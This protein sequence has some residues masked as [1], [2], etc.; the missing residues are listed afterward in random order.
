MNL[1]GWSIIRTKDLTVYKA[2]HVKVMKLIKCS[3]WFSGWSDLD[4]IWRYIFDDVN[5]GGI[6][7][8]RED[9]AKVRGTDE[10]GN[11]LTTSNT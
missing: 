7:L 3:R 8:A 2:D 4:I 9:Y 5:Y 6:E 11:T 10:Y 1:F